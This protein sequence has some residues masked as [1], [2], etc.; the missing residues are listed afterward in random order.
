M[1]NNLSDLTLYY[2]YYSV[3]QNGSFSKTA[4]ILGVTQPSISYSIKKL[5]KTLNVKLFERKN[6]LILTPEGE[7]L[8]PY[9]ESAL[10]NLKNG[11]KKINELV[12]LKK[13]VIKIGVP[14]HIGVF[15]LTDI[16]KKF[17]NKYPNIKIKVKCANTKELFSLLG[18]NSLDIVIDSSPLADNILEYIIIKI[19]TERC[20]FACNKNRKELLNRKLKLE[21]LNKYNLIVPSRNSSSTKELIAIYN[22][23]KL[24]YDPMYEVS[25]S[26]IIV[27]MLEKNM[28]IGFLFEK[29]IDKYENLKKV[30]I[31]CKL[32]TF[33]IFIIYRD[34]LL[35]T[36]TLEFIKFTSRILN[37]SRKV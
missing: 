18:T 16:I 23:K 30:E 15:L 29:T 19:S 20:A 17:N 2:I 32:P 14:S 5:E 10:N 35:S 13:G 34:Y 9:V 7:Q 31:D 37:S 1:N 25:T 12:H 4:E 33:D 3:C 22:K 28:G 11:E 26:D 6:K 8:L 27:D 36:A 24:E 21:D